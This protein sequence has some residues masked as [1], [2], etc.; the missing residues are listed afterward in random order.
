[1]T[2]H[3]PYINNYEVGVTM[4]AVEL[5]KLYKKDYVLRWTVE[6]HGKSFVSSTNAHA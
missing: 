6:C 4:G 3:L 1:M 5:S 2:F